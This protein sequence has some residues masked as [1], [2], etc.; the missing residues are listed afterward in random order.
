MKLQ[1]KKIELGLLVFVF[2]VL[3]FCDCQSLLM[4]RA[5]YIDSACLGFIAHR[6]RCSE[7]FFG[8]DK[9]LDTVNH[10][11][12]EGLLGS[13]ESSS[14]G[15]IENSIVSLGVLSVDSSNLNVVLIGNSIELV[16]GLHE[17]WKLDVH[18]SSESGSQVRWARGNVSEMLIV[19]ELADGLDVSGGSAKSVEY[20]KDTSSL[21][22][23]DDS[24]LILLIDPDEESLRVV[25]EDSSSGWPVSVK[26]ASSKESVS[27]PNI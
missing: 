14:V 21:L 24:Q 5:D 25:V 23:G 4:S 17:L 26:V 20:L 7:C 11:L 22:H 1:L 3:K 19:G 27:L 16:L 15:D 6:A 8:F 2:K 10:V 18:G 12:D 9:G 13:S